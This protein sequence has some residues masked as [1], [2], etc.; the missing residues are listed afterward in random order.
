MYVVYL[1]VFILAGLYSFL[2]KIFQF[3]WQNKKLFSFAFV[4]S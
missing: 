3:I 4:A 1:M 2:E